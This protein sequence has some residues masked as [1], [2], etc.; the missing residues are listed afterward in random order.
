MTLDPI[1]L[2]RLQFVWV[3]GWHIL[4]PAFTVGLASYIAFMEGLYFVTRREVYFRISSFWTKIFSVSF[5][6]GV[7]S[8]II[9]P[10]QFG[11]NWS[12]FSDATANILSPLFA[13]E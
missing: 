12:R 9:M 2:S 13:Y 3:I 1:I 5:G 7:V 8:G 4:P 10:F 6:M 11:T